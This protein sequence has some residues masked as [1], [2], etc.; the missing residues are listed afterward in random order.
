MGGKGTQQSGWVKLC[1]DLIYDRWRLDGI[2]RRFRRCAEKM[3]AIAWDRGASWCA[4]ILILALAWTR[5]HGNHFVSSHLSLRTA[6]G[7]GRSL[8]ASP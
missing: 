4:V 5:S 8:F 3:P 1:G 7:N 2:I 6:L